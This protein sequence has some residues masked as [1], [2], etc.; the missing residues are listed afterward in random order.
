MTVEQFIQSTVEGPGAL[1]PEALAMH[2]AGVAEAEKNLRDARQQSDAAEQRIVSLTKRQTAINKRLAEVQG[3]VRDKAGL[4]AVIADLRAAKK[5]C[6]RRAALEQEERLLSEG[7]QFL[8]A[9]DMA[10][11]ELAVKASRLA[12]RRAQRAWVDAKGRSEAAKLWSDLAPAMRR[13]P[14]LTIQMDRGGVVVEYVRKL[15]EIEGEVEALQDALAR[16]TRQVRDQQARLG[17]LAE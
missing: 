16:E 1:S 7:L 4:R 13:D 12:I 15:N 10:D 9:G 11:A 5:E 2:E 14:N 8:V 17:V 6:E 3:Q